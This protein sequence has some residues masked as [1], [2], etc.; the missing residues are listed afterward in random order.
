VVLAICA[1]AGVAAALAGAAGTAGVTRNVMFGTFVVAFAIL[2]PLVATIAWTAPLRNAERSAARGAGIIA[3][4]LAVATLCVLRLAGIAGV[5]APTV[6]VLAIIAGLIMLGAAGLILHRANGES[7]HRWMRAADRAVGPRALPALTALMLLLLAAVFAPEQLSPLGFGAA[8]LLA[9]GAGVF[10]LRKQGRTG[11]TA[12]SAVGI[13]LEVLLVGALALICVDLSGYWGEDVLGTPALADHPFYYELS[14][15]VQ[16]H[17]HFFLGAVN[18][19][20]RGRTLLVDSNAVYGIGNTYLIA[21]WFK[22]LPLNYGLFT[23]FGSLMAFTAM[24]VGWAIARLAGAT[25]AVAAVALAVATMAAVLNP[26]Y[27]PTI[28]VN[29]GGLRFLPA[30][31]PVLAAL[32]SRREEGVSR[33]PLVLA[34]MGFFSIWSVEA[35]TYSFGAWFGLAAL[36]AARATTWRAVAREAVKSA[37]A[38]A[39]AWIGTHLLFGLATLAA[40]GSWPDW[41]D[42][43]TLF[44]AWAG[45][46]NAF[47]TEVE[48]WSRSWLVGGFYLASVGGFVT[49]ARTSLWSSALD[50][51]A[52][53][54]VAGLTGGGIA[55]LSYFVSHTL[56]F[57]L[58]YT[59]VPAT[60]LVA[61]WLCLALRADALGRGW[62]AAAAGTGVFLATA[63]LIGSYGAARERFPATALAHVIPGGP[64][65]AEDLDQLWDPPTISPSTPDAVELIERNFP[66][67]FA[68]VLVEPDVGQEALLETERANLLPIAYPWQDQVDLEHT[69]PAVLEAVDELEPGTRLL[70][71]EPPTPDSEPSVQQ[72]FG[73][74]PLDARLGPLAQAALDR[75]EED[76]VLRRIDEGPDGLYVAELVRRR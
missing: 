68:L 67:D 11:R 70:L 37:L 40:S 62:R 59:T 65:V 63:M 46:I 35:L 4:V 50:R 24:L 26:V 57:Y 17:Q 15:S 33:S 13:A 74:V 21:L 25:R 52:L 39:A 56:D 72:R 64:S 8:V 71:Q 44:D 38:L 53:I 45:V 49:L 2:L 32:L 55:L 34:T 58:L 16:I 27:P 61:V 42:Y 12:P 3:G 31:I 60:L 54:A 22:L 51:R 7:E 76:W 69:L 10:V 30:F 73:A 36:D 6:R 48:S 20:L 23:M 18:D 19:V 28:F 47:G 5:S 75:I 41:L 9:A 66:D 29:L 14:A 43:L 1:S